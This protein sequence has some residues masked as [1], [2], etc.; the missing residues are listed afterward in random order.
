MSNSWTFY[1]ADG[2]RKITGAGET[3]PEGPEGP[4]GTTTSV[5][6]MALWTSRYRFG[7]G[8]ARRLY[9]PHAVTITQVDVF[10]GDNAPSQ[11]LTLDLLKNGSSIL[12]STFTLNSGDFQSGAATIADP[13]VAVDDYLQFEVVNAGSIT[14][15]ICGRILFEYPA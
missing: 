2:S 11:T 12:S 10:A 1:A 9:F 7:L 15:P 5:E 3:G 8:V 4:P 14:G 13:D 6:S